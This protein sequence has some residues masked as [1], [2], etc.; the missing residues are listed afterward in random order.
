MRRLIL[1]RHAPTAASRRAAFPLDEPLDAEALAAATMLAGRLPEAESVL[2]SPAR[3]ARQSA[4]A[5]ELEPVT[6][7]LLA[8][9]DF[10]AWAGFTLAEVHAEDATAAAAWMTDPDAT[11][12]GG[13][14]LTAFAA[15]VAGWLAAQ[16]ETE[17]TTIAYT[18][19]G[20]IAAAVVHALDAPLAAVWKL[21]P[22]PLS[23]TELEGEDGHW[24]VRRVGA[25]DHPHDGW[26]A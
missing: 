22:A 3:R 18:H 7:P 12:H 26:A 15:R 6:E 23:L 21:R 1:V 10:G 14:T 4:I 9:C 16:L 17:G 2:C 11:P 8:E 24:T 13:E 19:G 5:A 25:S 20:V